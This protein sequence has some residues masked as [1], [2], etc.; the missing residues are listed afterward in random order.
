MAKVH[1]KSGDQVQILT[2][3]DQGKKGKVLEVNPKT[4]K[5]F[6][7]GINIQKKHARPT[8]SNPQGGVIERPGP[9]DASN[10]QIICHSCRKPTRPRRERSANG[11]ITRMCR[12]CGK[13]ID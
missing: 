7:E 11:E 5:V 2:G 6:V 10:V 12:D 9:I 4:G 13:T 3:E 1:V 8:Q